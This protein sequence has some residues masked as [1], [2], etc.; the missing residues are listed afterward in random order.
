MNFL[1]LSRVSLTV[2][3]WGPPI[4]NKSTILVPC[5][6][7]IKLLFKYKTGRPLCHPL[8]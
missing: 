7:K 8:D 4:S 2:D 6:E 5:V 3:W 1:H